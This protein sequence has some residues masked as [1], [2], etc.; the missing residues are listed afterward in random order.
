ML[1]VKLTTHG[2]NHVELPK[3]GYTHVG[4]KDEYGAVEIK[5]T[6]LTKGTERIEAT[7]NDSVTVLLQLSRLQYY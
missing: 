6:L 4:T 5:C 3:Y 1:Y 7:R 2:F